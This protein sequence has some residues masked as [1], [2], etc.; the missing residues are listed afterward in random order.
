MALDEK[1]KT[2]KQK[3]KFLYSNLI[4]APRS[5]QLGTVICLVRLGLAAVIEAPMPSAEIN[6][7]L[8][9]VGGRPGPFIFCALNDIQRLVLR[10]LN[11]PLSVASNYSWGILA[12]WL[13]LPAPETQGAGGAASLM[14]VGG[15]T[16]GVPGVPLCP[17]ESL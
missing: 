7:V 3:Q 1:K 16:T 2:K 9:V 15:S 11:G 13:I 14:L 5:A 17:T 8:V 10:E 12:D 6:D 4:T